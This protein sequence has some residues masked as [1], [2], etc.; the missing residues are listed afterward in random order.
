[1]AEV[2]LARYVGP[3]GFEKRLVIKR[4]LPR[5]NHDQ[6]LLRMFFEEAKTHVSLSH[7]NLVS[8]FDFGRVGNDY[9]IAMEHVE[10][11]DLAAVL[12]AAGGPLPPSLVAH[13]G[14]ELCR[15]LAYVHRRGFVHRDVT[16]RNVLL[17]LDGEVKLSDFGLV[18]AAEREDAPG[19]R[20]T[21]AYI[22]PEQARAERVDGRGDL[23]SLGVV[24][25]E[26]VTGK[27]V[28]SAATVEEALEKARA[29]EPLHIEG[30]LAEVIARATQT[31]PADRFANADEMLSAIEKESLGSRESAI[32]ELARRVAEIAPSLSVPARVTGDASTQPAETVN[33]RR[34]P[35]EETYFRDSKSESIVDEI[36]ARPKRWGWIFALAAAGVI[37]G[38]VALR[39][40]HVERPIV[41]LG[42]IDLG[43][44][45]LGT[46]DLG[47][48]D[49]APPVDLA[50][51]I[52]LAPAEITHP[53][54]KRVYGTLQIQ[55]TPWC[56][57]FIDG[58]KSGQDGRN[59]SLRV[60]VGRHQIEARRLDDRQKR[61]LSIHEGAQKLEF[62]FE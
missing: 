61:E 36:L 13:L 27:R 54:A 59:H 19:V 50:R 21:L 6:H 41:D 35:S 4:V 55:C 30:P 28:R 38:G 42:T 17:S 40:A 45:D 53:K 33:E 47:T 22:P 26:A 8:V 57:P 44:I 23:F 18:L 32:R 25:A 52:D 20:G 31:N 37:A 5:F 10:G 2:F 14:I 3:E 51:P 12:T 29:G 43:T 46:I 9:F 39:A 15:G 49:L 58:Q 48:I 60:L 16:P 34:R 62:K 11:V 7:G 1:M 56:I 24:L